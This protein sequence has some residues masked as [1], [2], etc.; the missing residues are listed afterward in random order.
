[1][2]ATYTLAVIH[3]RAIGDT[4]LMPLPE[5]FQTKFSLYLRKDAGMKITKPQ[6]ELHKTPAI[7]NF[8]RD[9]HSLIGKRFKTP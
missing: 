6:S 2:T 8:L 7:Q 4:N 5:A 1:M 3:R 9:K